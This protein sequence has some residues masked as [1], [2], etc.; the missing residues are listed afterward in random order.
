MRKDVSKT[1]LSVASSAGRGG[2][3]LM[4]ESSVRSLNRVMK[5]LNQ[6]GPGDYEIPSSFGSRAMN[7][8]LRN[9]P[10]ISFNNRLPIPP[11]REF[12]EV[13]M[14]ALIDIASSRKAFSW[15]YL[16]YS[17]TRSKVQK[18]QTLHGKA[19]SVLWGKPENQKQSHWT[20]SIPGE[21]GKKD[22]FIPQSIF[23]RWTSTWLNFILTKRIP[24]SCL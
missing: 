18:S 9:T 13:N 16:R 5:I 21:S 22:Q 10:S 6:A 20:D 24:W 1:N 8:K 4:R 11:T 19:V 7:S 14:A 3:S 2:G 12:A 15:G 17:F 23:W